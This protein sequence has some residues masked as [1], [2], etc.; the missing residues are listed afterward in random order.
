MPPKTSSA[1]SS[2]T[3]FFSPLG[4]LNSPPNLSK[5][6]GSLHYVQDVQIASTKNRSRVQGSR[7][8]SDFFYGAKFGSFHTAAPQVVDQVADHAGQTPE[9]DDRFFGIWFGDI[10][11]IECD[12]DLRTHFATGGLCDV[13]KLNKFLVTSTLKSFGDI[14]HNRNRSPLDLIAQRKVFRKLFCFS[15]SI[16]DLGQPARFLPNF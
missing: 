6:R 16:N 9:S 12:V 7:V 13:K 8:Q 11:L 10:A 2:T 15:E 4:I 3:P 1:L 14:G 5:L